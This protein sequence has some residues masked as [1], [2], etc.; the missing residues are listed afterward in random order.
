MALLF[1]RELL[2]SPRILILLTP[3]N[4]QII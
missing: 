3:E 4:I 2:K 1:E